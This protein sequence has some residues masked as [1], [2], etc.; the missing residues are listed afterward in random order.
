[1]KRVSG[2]GETA[3]FEA[4]AIFFPDG[5]GM[6][7]QVHA[8]ATAPTAAIASAAPMRIAVR[9]YPAVRSDGARVWRDAVTEF[10]SDVPLRLDDLE[11]R[12]ACAGSGPCA[13]PRGLPVAT[14][15]HMIRWQHQLIAAVPP[16][17]LAQLAP[18][19]PA[20]ASTVAATPDASAAQ[21]KSVPPDS[22]P[23]SP[24]QL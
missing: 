24:P 8:N 21:N 17:L 4:R 1:L 6:V 11:A 10:D 9:Y 18:P 16:M 5:S 22:P 13:P 7:A 12:F 19:P 2:S 20:P 23:A 3:L 14:G 15:F